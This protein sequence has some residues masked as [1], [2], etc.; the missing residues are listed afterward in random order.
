MSLLIQSPLL[1]YVVYSVRVLNM[2]YKNV[3]VCSC[4]FHLINSQGSHQFNLLCKVWSKPYRQGEASSKFL[5]HNEHGT[6]K[7][8]SNE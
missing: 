3:S 4:I 1:Y 6:Q 2:S 8:H 5:L 7:K